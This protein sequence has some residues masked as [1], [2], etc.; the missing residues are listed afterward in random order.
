P[1]DTEQVVDEAARPGS[2]SGCPHPHRPDQVDHV[3][4]GEEVRRIAELRDDPELVGEPL[5]DHRVLVW[6]VPTPD[7]RLAPGTQRCIAWRHPTTSVVEPFDRLR[8]S[9][10]D[11]TGFDDVELREVDFAEP[12][13]CSWVEGESIGHDPGPGDQPVGLPLIEACQSADLVGDV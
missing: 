4:D 13:V 2:A 6:R 5:L 11:T 7:R 3:G 1:G 9:L 12:E 8:T 10:V